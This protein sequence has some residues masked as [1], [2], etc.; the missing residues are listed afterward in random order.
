MTTLRINSIESFSTKDGDGIRSVIFLQ[1]CPLRC[2]YCH[3]PETWNVESGEVV[4]IDQLAYKVLR[5]ADYWGENGGITI[6][7]GEPL[8]QAKEL[9]EFLTFIKPFGVNV[10]LDTSGCIINDNVRELIGMVDHVILD[11]KDIKDLLFLEEL[12]KQ[13]KRVWVRIVIV[14]NVNDTE[15]VVTEYANAL[16]GRGIE[17]TEL[18]PFHTLGFEKYEK[19]GIVN[20]LG[21]TKGMSVSGTVK[22]QRCF[23]S[24]IK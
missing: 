9:V 10:A 13:N 20:P 22:L 7:G 16:K 3:N 18:V 4:T 5:F 17:K 1:G 11:L 8:M 23:D 14:P 19:M 21:N 24:I 15:Q 12:E 2:D 6:S